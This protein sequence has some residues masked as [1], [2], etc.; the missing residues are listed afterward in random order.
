MNEKEKRKRGGIGYRILDFIAGEKSSKYAVPI[1]SVTLSLIV[2]AVVLLAMDK[3][4]ITC[5]VSFLQGCGI[6]PKPNYAAGKGMLADFFTFLGF[7]APMLLAALGIVM[8]MR[9]NLF[10]IGV[11][12][13]MLAAGFT[14][15]V[16]VGYSDLS[17]AVAR[18]LVI[19]IGAVVGALIGLFVGLLKYKFNIHEVVSTIILNYIINYVI[20]FFI[21]T[22][23]ADP[24]TRA[25]RNCS[26]E[27]RLT[28]TN[29]QIGDMSVSIPLGILVAAAGVAFVKIFLD[30]T[31]AGFELKSV[32]LNREC[33][34]Y[35]GM[36]VN[37]NILIAMGLSGMFAGLAG[38]TY[39]L[40]YYN[41]IYPNS[42][43][44]M[45]YDCIAVALVGNSSPIGAIFGSIL[46]SI[47]QAGSVYMNSTMNV[48]KEITSVIT[49][50]ILLF[51]AC[52]GFIIYLANRR[53][54]K[55][56]DAMEKET[57]ENE[58]KEA[59]K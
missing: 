38:V 21:N 12:G 52:G 32:G 57:K 39:Y 42:L 41:N 19:L 45:G 58:E 34:K 44:S 54:S 9:A 36:N 53:K 1:I 43:S 30:N 40:G 2:A 55:M 28:I 56:E 29:V 35:A 16:I 31:K 49:G 26:S 7:L 3:N 11:S 20:G 46:I 5:F 22:Y 10:N 13:Q 33:A 48:A 50:I 51:S 6:V 24:L 23:F 59:S 14:A 8:G 15:T 27:A 17:A 25:A 18:P 37:R 47:L 4:P